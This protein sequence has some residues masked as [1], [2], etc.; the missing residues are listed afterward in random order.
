MGQR[1]VHYHCPSC[2]APQ[3][4]VQRGLCD[5]C[6]AP[7]VPLGTPD[8]STSIRCAGCHSLVASG[9]SF[10]PHC[11]H[12]TAAFDSATTDFECPSCKSEAPHMMRWGLAPTS[13]RPTGHEIDGCTHCGGVW[14]SHEVLMRMLDEARAQAMELEVEE[15]AVKRRVMTERPTEVVYRHCP[16]CAD[17]MARKNFER[18]SGIIL[19]SCPR[20]GTFFD[21]GE[22]EDTLDFVR[23]GGLVL[24]QRKREAEEERLQ[25]AREASKVPVHRQGSL[26]DSS[27]SAFGI[28]AFDARSPLDSSLGELT[29]AFLRWGAGWTRK[30]GRRVWLGLRNR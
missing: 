27:H 19:D 9:S 5:Y 29:L 8:P 15:R 25:R 10:C 21:A 3:S 12:A 30:V 2:G 28:G 18:V 7:R 24:A 26:G 22:L 1:A 17:M 13:E 6:S 16:L 20:H 23:T 4:D 11:G 14:V